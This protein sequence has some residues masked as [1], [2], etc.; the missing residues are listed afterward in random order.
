MMNEFQ[1]YVRDKDLNV[2][3]D[4]MKEVRFRKKPGKRCGD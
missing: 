1:Y 3:V 4:R 2:N